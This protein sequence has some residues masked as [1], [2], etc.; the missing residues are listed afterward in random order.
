[1]YLLTGVTFQEKL[2]ARA[3]VPTPDGWPGA[4]ALR[5]AAVSTMVPVRLRGLFEPR[6]G[7]EELELL[8]SGILKLR[9]EGC[10]QRLQDQGQRAR[11]QVSRRRRLSLDPEGGLR[12]L[13]LMRPPALHHACG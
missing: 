10:V 9:G 11:T 4:R 6:Q 2:E 7:L 12:L 3:A 13:P 8:M 1:M 5:A